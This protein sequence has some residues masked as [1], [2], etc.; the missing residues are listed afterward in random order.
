MT[1]DVTPGTTQVVQTITVTNPSPTSTAYTGVTG[2]VLNGSTVTLSGVLTDAAKAPIAGAP[3]TMT[4]GSGAAAQTCSAATNESRNCGCT[5]VV[6][7]AAGPQDLVAA[8]AGDATHAASAGASNV[9]VQTAAF[10]AKSLKQGVLT[11]AQTLLAAASRN[12]AR[13]LRSVVSSVYAALNPTLWVDGNH[14]QAKH[15]GEVFDD[16]KDAVGTLLDLDAHSGIPDA[17]LQGMIYTLAAADQLLAES[18][19]PAT[20]NAQKIAE[21]RAKLAKASAALAGGHAD[22]AIGFYKNAWKAGQQAA[23]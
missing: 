17:T 2:A 13:K 22:D 7:Q 3:L 8:Y 16:E 12:D 6:N 11:Q 1:S 21:A 9:V 10:T 5:V 19:I 4:L 23:G 18:A 20:G 14:L 15:G